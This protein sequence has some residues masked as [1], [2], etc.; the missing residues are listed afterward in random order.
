VLID[1]HMGDRR[2]S[3]VGASSNIIEASWRALSDAVEYG[4]TVAAAE[5]GSGEAA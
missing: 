1:T 3:T 2:W 5:P 4:L